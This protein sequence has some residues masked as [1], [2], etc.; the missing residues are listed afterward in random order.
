[1]K[2]KKKSSKNLVI[3]T[4]LIVSLM[5]VLVLLNQNSQK[6][7]STEGVFDKAPATENQPTLGDKNSKVSIVEFGDFKCP[8]CKA[9]GENIMP[10]LSKD[11]IDSQKASFSYV[12]VLFH[13]EESMTGALA[14]EAI[15]LQ[16]P[17]AYW[18]FHHELFNAQ[19][20]TERHDEL[21]LTPEKVLE[22]AKEHTPNINLQKLEEDM[23]SKEIKDKVS[24][25]DQL[26]REFNV[27]QTPT[28]M[29][30]NVMVSNPFDYEEISAIINAELNK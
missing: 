6:S 1:M 10:Q 25:D 24:A 30:N 5:V 7:K 9:W 14:A 4:I 17:E 29:I 13:G 28:I 26:V 19:P 15:L 20:E 16:D 23:G 2:N 12:N 8:S 22:L 3:F 18:T 27:Q 21:W 11:F